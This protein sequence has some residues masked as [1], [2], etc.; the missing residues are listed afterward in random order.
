MKRTSIVIT[1]SLLLAALAS[2]SAFAQLTVAKKDNLELWIGVN[3]VGTFQALDQKNAFNA[4]NETLGETDPGFQTAWGDLKFGLFYGEKKDI[5]MFFDVYLASRP[6][7]SQTYGHQGYLLIHNL[8]D[9]I[10]VP[11]VNNALK[12]VDIKVGAFEI[13]YGDQWMHRSNNA[14]VQRNPLIGNFVLDPNSTEVGGEII[15]KPNRWGG[16]LVGVASGTTT[17]NFSEGRPLGYHGKVWITPVKPIRASFSIYDVD[18]SDTAPRSSGG[19]G[20]T[21]ITG[22]RSGERYGGILGGGQ[23]PGGVLTN[24]GKDV[25]MWEAAVTADF[26]RAIFFADYGRAEDNDVN[27]SLA[28]KPRESWNYYAAQGTLK[29]TEKFYGAARYSVAEADELATRSSNGKVARYQVGGG[30]WVN[31]YLLAKLEYVHQN[32]DGFASGTVVNGVR[33]DRSPEFSGPIMEV[34]FNF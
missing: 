16:A 15:T 19:S 1:L 23:A 21:I 4:K 9:P 8:P 3:T 28:G 29:L 22:N 33:V 7:P 11:F 12:Y 13:D 24:I 6:H 20:A 30:Y 32:Y 34:S 26:G 31:K 5:E 17:E 2:T 10:A 18:H 25:T 27:G 14:D